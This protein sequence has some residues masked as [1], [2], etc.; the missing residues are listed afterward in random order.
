MSTYVYWTA[1]TIPNQATHF[2]C[3]T[4]LGCRWSGRLSPQCVTRLR[5]DGG[6]QGLDAHSRRQFVR[7]NGDRSQ[8][9]L[10]YSLEP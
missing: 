3:E 6:D 7:R 1:D 5:A 8:A 4:V 2:H 9:E 10:C